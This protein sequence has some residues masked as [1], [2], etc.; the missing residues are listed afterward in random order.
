MESRERT[1]VVLGPKGA[2]KATTTGCMLF[3]VSM[4]GLQQRYTIL[5]VTQYGAIEM[6]TMDMF[7]RE[8]IATYDQAA[9]RL[10]RDGV[11]TAF[12]TPKYHVTILGKCSDVVWNHTLIEKID[13]PSSLAD[14]AMLVLPADNLPVKG[15]LKDY[16][17]VARKLIVVVNKM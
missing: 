15:T 12:E 8:G 3:Q 10:K 17:N 16:V 9:N 4:A 5:I 6:T 7:Q 13:T 14:C 2:G 11:A 1:L